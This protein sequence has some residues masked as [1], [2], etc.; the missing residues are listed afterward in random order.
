MPPRCC[1]S[2]F[3]VSGHSR[4]VP[5]KS[6]LPFHYFDAF[7][8]K[9]VGYQDSCS[10]YID[11]AMHWNN[12]G[13]SIFSGLSASHWW[14]GAISS[15]FPQ[16]FWARCPWTCWCTCV[17]RILQLDPLAPSAHL[18]SRTSKPKS[19]STDSK[20]SPSDTSTQYK[21]D[22]RTGFSFIRQT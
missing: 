9:P 6:E 18:S 2:W 3:S 5:W 15:A 17:C 10:F 4:G 20:S 1:G 11:S 21:N 22:H 8:L 7:Q 19:T 14:S 13:R 12:Y 16:L